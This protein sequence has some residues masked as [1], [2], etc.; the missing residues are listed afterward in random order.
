M[1]HLGEPLGGAK[2]LLEA[3]SFKKMKEGM[4]RGR[5]ANTRWKRVPHSGGC[6][7]KTTGGEDT[8]NRH[9]HYILL[10]VK[11]TV[12]YSS[13]CRCILSNFVCVEIYT[14]FI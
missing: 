3:V 9:V 1:K 13:F 8:A 5:V 14:V 10:L 7:T 12:D 6:N 11:P 2:S 4:G